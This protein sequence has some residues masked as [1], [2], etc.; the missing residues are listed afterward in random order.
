MSG[1]LC[2]EEMFGNG[3]LIQQISIEKQQIQEN[4]D[5]KLSDDAYGPFHGQV[6]SIV[7]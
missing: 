7:K 1:P 6:I 2:E 4:A 5:I 3:F